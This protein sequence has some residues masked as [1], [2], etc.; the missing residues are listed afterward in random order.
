MEVPLVTSSLVLKPSKV[1]C[2]L[3][4]NEF[5][6]M[7]HDWRSTYKGKLYQRV[8]W[9]G[10]KGDG[11][12]DVKCT[13]LSDTE[14]TIYQCK[15]YDKKLTPYYIFK[16][17]GKCCY[18]IFKKVYPLPIKYLF[19][20]PHGVTAEVTDLFSNPLKLKVD[21]KA[22]WPNTCETHIQASRIPLIG[23][24]EKFID[25]FDFSIFNYVSPNEFL[26]DF[27]NTCYYSKYF[28]MIK[29]ARP[30]GPYDAPEQYGENEL[31]YIQKLLAVYKEYSQ[32]EIVNEAVLKS[33]KPKLYDEFKRHRFYFYSADCLAE[34]SREV[35]PPEMPWFEHCKKEFYYGI[36]D[37]VSEDAEHGYSRL[38]KVIKRATDLDIK[39]GDDPSVRLRVQDKRGMCHH[40]A[41]EREDIVWTKK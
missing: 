22:V 20:S 26:E 16:E 1:L 5:E 32:E 13:G 25:N 37:E 21:L 35:F 12:R 29:K 11:G 2:S 4:D 9:L 19:I 40:L 30:L 3:E 33:L 31:D 18:N 23:D 6:E 36:I 7:I 10:G 41:N 28:K 39:L 38:K 8:E 14:I 27:E 24:F 17:V 15:N 34:Y